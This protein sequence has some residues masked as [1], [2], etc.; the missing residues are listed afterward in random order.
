MLN[1]ILKLTLGA[2][3]AFVL[4]GCGG[5]SESPREVAVSFA[6]KTAN[7]DTKDL[8]EAAKSFLLDKLEQYPQI[9]KESGGL[10]NLE[11]AAEHIKGDEA[12]VEVLVNFKDGSSKTE[13]VTL[14]K[15]NNKWVFA[16]IGSLR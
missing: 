15:E 8:S 9:A 1:K 6:T 12:K 3:L 2:T 14:K 4:I 7:G 16:N 13:Y 11:V 5:N 10:K